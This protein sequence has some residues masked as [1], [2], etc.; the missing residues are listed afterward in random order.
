MGR[1]P[2]S[3]Q[4]RMA[5]AGIDVDIIISVFVFAVDNVRSVE[6]VV[7]VNWVVGPKAISID[8]E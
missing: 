3:H 2:A 8:G 7:L 6:R 5:L 1:E 4:R